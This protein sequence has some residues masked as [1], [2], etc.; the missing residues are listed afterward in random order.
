MLCNA[1]HVYWQDSEHAEGGDPVRDS[2]AVGGVL[3]RAVA[4]CGV[5]ERMYRGE[6][7]SNP[8]TLYMDVADAATVLLARGCDAGAQ[9]RAALAALQRLAT[10]GPDCVG[11]AESVPCWSDAVQSRFAAIQGS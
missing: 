3:D 8:A 7:A 10:S 9:Q 4:M 5:A 2:G 11:T 6:A 1:S